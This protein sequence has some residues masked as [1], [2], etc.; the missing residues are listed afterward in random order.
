VA[1]G[2]IRRAARELADQCAVA[3]DA[4]AQ[5]RW[6]PFC[7]PRSTEMTIA[8]TYLDDSSGIVG[9]DLQQTMDLYARACVAAPPDPKRLAG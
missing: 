4:G 7:A 2:S 5:Q 6:S 9:D 3:I 8:L 1:G